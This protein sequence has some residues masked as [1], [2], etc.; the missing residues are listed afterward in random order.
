M[1]E[2]EPLTTLFDVFCS[3]VQ[4][5]IYL[6]LSK[7]RFDISQGKIY[8][9]ILFTRNSAVFLCF[10]VSFCYYD[11]ISKILSFSHL[12]KWTIHMTNLGTRN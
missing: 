10:M 9:E 8:M 5:V 4:T 2:N 12:L 1:G 3:V 11:H 6:I 7:S